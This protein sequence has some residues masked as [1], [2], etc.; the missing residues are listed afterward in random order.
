MRQR[1]IA[2]NLYSLIVLVDQVAACRKGKKK[3]A[4]L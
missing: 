1:R 3:H 2:G 4:G